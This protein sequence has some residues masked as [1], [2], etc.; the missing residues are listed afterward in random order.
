MKPRILRFCGNTFDPRHPDA[1]QFVHATSHETHAQALA[2]HQE[3]L[4]NKMIGDPQPGRTPELTVAA[5]RDIHG[6]VGV[7]TTELDDYAKRCPEEVL[8]RYGGW[9]MKFN[10]ATSQWETVT[11]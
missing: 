11:P 1:D 2:R 9:L 3:W 5:L 4:S 6:S 7:Y 10:Q 8:R